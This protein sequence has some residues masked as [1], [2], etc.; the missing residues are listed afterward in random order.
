MSSLGFG[1]AHCRRRTTFHHR[2][3]PQ[4]SPRRSVNVLPKR[5]DQVSLGRRRKQ[6][7]EAMRAV[8]QRVASASVEVCLQWCVWSNDE[9]ETSQLLCLLVFFSLVNLVND[10]PVTMQLDSRQLSKN[11][12]GEAEGS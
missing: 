12:N 2:K 6:T 4:I 5:T 10:G 3:Q 11:S 8:V 7:I 1:I 9:S